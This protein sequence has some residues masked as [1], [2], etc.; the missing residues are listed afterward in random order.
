MFA[1]IGFIDFL[2]LPRGFFSSLF[3]TGRASSLLVLFF[4]AFF[5]GE[6]FRLLPEGL[7]L[8]S[9]FSSPPSPVSS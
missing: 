1:A 5:F 4:S 8:T 9:V 3:L 2:G 7:D 6:V